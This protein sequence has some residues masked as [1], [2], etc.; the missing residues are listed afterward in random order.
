MNKTLVK[1]YNKM[2]ANNKNRFHK[3]NKNKNDNYI[4]NYFM[5]F[6]LQ[7]YSSKYYLY[8]SL[9]KPLSFEISSLNP[10]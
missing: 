6:I 10:L 4:Y 2:S 7:N 8:Y 5:T 1:I 9:V 3:S